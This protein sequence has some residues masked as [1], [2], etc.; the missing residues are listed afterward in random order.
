MIHTVYIDDSTL[1]GRRML[2]EMRKN[3]EGIEFEENNISAVAEPAVEYVKS[4]KKIITDSSVEYMT[5]D[6]FWKEADKRISKICKDHG[7]L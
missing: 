4:D 7:V 5:S 1:N 2:E 3:N 6:E